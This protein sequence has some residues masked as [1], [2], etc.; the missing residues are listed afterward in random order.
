MNGSLPNLPGS[1]GTRRVCVLRLGWSPPSS[2]TVVMQLFCPT[3]QAAFPGSQRCPRCGGLLLR[4]QEAAAVTS[5]TPAQ[6]PPPEEATPTSRVVIG[7]VFAV[8]LYLGFRKLAM[9]FVAAAHPDPASWWTS[10]Q[11]VTA[12]CAWQVVAVMLG[13]LVAAAGRVSGFSFG[14]V[15][16]GVGGVLVLAG[17]LAAGA[18]RGMMLLIQPG[19]MVVVGAATGFIASRVWAALPTLEMPTINVQKLD[20]T[21]LVLEETA[22]KV[23]PTAWI[24]ILVGA[25]IIVGA[26]ASA[27]EIRSGAQR[28]SAGMLHTTTAGQGHF[29]TWQ[30]GLFGMLLG[31]IIAS[32]GT[33]AGVRHGLTAGV[34]GAI[35]ILAVSFARG[36]PVSPIAYWLT[37]LTLGD[38]SASHPMV[39]A[40][41]FGGVT[42]L[43][44]LGGWLGGEILQPLGSHAQRK[45]V[46][47]GLD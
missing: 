39:I 43:S 8:G 10:S 14:A 11:A 23:R 27:E 4:P 33:G 40:A 37:H 2:G 3:C 41:S 46:N 32:G 5:H 13:S 47:L 9:G 24:Q 17:E 22:Q 16:G 25:A 12:I 15:V 7:A 28:F 31:S 29:M 21:Q 19:I 1:P 20:P 38:L 26:A 6:P 30:V 34:L 35:G 44:L 18:P 45:A 36:E 42:F